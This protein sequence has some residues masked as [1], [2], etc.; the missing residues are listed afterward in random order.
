ML[1]VK[2]FII[3]K[4]SLQDM[5]FELVFEVMLYL[6]TE[7]LGGKERQYYSDKKSFRLF[8]HVLTWIVC[9]I[10]IILFAVILYGLASL[11]KWL[12][13]VNLL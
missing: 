11:I 8:A 5:L 1:L 2:R 10:G 9:L 3:K 12:F 6:W 7:Y 13:G 4:G